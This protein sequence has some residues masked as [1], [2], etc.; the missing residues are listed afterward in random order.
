MRDSENEINIPMTKIENLISHLELLE[1]GAIHIESEYGIG[2]GILT[3]NIEL[4]LK[5]IKELISK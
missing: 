1:L 5:Q 3:N 4:L 2:D